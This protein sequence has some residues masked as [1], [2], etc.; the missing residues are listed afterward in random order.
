MLFRSWASALHAAIVGMQSVATRSFA[1]NVVGSI[2]KLTATLPDEHLKRT[3]VA[4]DPKALGDVLRRA[5]S[6]VTRE[7]N[8]GGTRR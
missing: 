3:R 6:Q 4:L 1:M 8:D 2:E 5:L 7:G